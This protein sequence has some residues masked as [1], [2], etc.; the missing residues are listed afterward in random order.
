MLVVDTNVLIYAANRD[1]PF[2]A[3][4]NGWLE[5]QR[6]KP[7]AWYSTW[8][9]VYEFLRVATHPRVLH[10]PWTSAEAWV[11]LKAIFAAPGF[12]LLVPRNRQADVLEQLLS[13]MPELAGNIMHDAHTV[14]LM[15]EHGVRRIVTRDSAFHR[16]GNIEV[17]DPASATA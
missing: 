16:F 1:S 7:D 11:F 3:A 5:A 6:G 14:S 2:H 4:C 15:R 10:K 8:P 9:I 12:S 13:E 17:F